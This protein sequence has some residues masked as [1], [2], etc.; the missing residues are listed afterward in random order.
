MGAKCT[1]CGKS[2]G[3]LSYI[4][5]G[6]ASRCSECKSKVERRVERF[7]C[8]LN[9]FA[10]DK[11]LSREE[12]QRLDEFLKNNNLRYSDIRR[13]GLKYSRIK[14]ATRLEHIKRYEDATYEAGEDDLLSNEEYARLQALKAKLDLSEA[15]LANINRYLFHLTTLSLV[16]EGI[17]PV[18]DSLNL[19]L[20]KGE[21]CHYRT[22]VRLVEE[23]RKNTFA[24][25]YDGISIRL[26]RGANYRFGRSKGT[27]IIKDYSAVTDNGYLYIT[28]KRVVFIGARKHVAYPIKKLVN[29]T[30]YSDAVKF[31]KEKEKKAKYFVLEDQFTIE[32]IGAILTAI[33]NQA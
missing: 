32:E 11:Y 27:K 30:K 2:L 33:V 23:K 6:Q 29:F 15:D 12:E 17:L 31:Q 22:F 18:V 19:S 20:Q 8:L 21:S 26:T 5:Q 1:V 28:N 25:R 13:F 9:E 10:D 24:G 16:E 4:S 7:G 14:K 3:L